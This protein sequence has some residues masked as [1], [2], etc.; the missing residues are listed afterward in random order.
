MSQPACAHYGP[1]TEDKKRLYIPG[2]LAASLDK[3]QVRGPFRGMRPHSK[4]SWFLHYKKQYAGLAA[5]TAWS[6][7]FLTLSQAQQESVKQEKELR[8][9]SASQA[10]SASSCKS[11]NPLRGHPLRG[12]RL[13]YFAVGAVVQDGL[14]GDLAA[15]AKAEAS[16]KAMFTA[17][18]GL[19]LASLQGKY[20]PWK[21]AL[22]ESWAECHSEPAVPAWPEAPSRATKFW[23]VL[24]KAVQLMDG[25]PYHQWHNHCGRGVAFHSGFLKLVQDLGL[26]VIS[27]PAADGPGAWAPIKLSCTAGRQHHLRVAASNASGASC[28][29]AV[30]LQV[31]K[32]LA[33]ADQ[34]NSALSSPPTTCQEYITKFKM[35]EKEISGLRAPHVGGGYTVPWTFRSA[36]VARMR[37]NGV[38]ALA[39]PEAV[40]PKEF[41]AAFPDQNDW[42]GQLQGSSSCQTLA[43]FT[44]LLSYQGPPELLTMKLCLHLE[45]DLQLYNPAW[46]WQN[47][48]QLHSGAQ[49][50]AGRL[51]FFPHIAVYLQMLREQW[52]A[53][54][55]E[56]PE[57]SLQLTAAT[58][59]PAVPAGP[60][61][62]IKGKGNGSPSCAPTKKARTATSAEEL[63]SAAS[64]P[65]TGLAAQS[66]DDNVEAVQSGSR[67]AGKWQSSPSPAA[68]PQ[69][70][71]TAVASILPIDQRLKTA[72]AIPESW[73]QA[74]PKAR[75]SIPPS[76]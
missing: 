32:Y 56:W 1:Y 9:S 73:L 46:L 29:T 55:A 65:P 31:D 42:I 33:A 45:A 3:E 50:L 10:S 34:L 52:D 13:T 14:Q 36:A 63:S 40:S 16:H 69:D 58:A 53:E 62:R 11:P 27:P 21:L 70:T 4:G 25:R 66:M 23:R 74:E 15:A 57:L 44:K 37:A 71:Q 39:E 8:N 59:V 7:A 48:D 54:Q 20:W 35:F 76:K 43:D 61:R 22:A 49:E 75:L 64:S 12:P 2:D 26:V 28:P 68:K 38:E 41:A 18:P 19:W 47:A 5:K 30:Q 24:H 60:K 17:E 51:G 67:A 6:E 72:L